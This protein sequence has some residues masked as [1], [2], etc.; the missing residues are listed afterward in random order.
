MSVR[1]VS[2][3]LQAQVGE[4]VAGLQRAK[5]ATGDF[6][7]ELAVSA[8]KGKGDLDAVARGAIIMGTALVGAVAGV[9][10]AG[11]RF[12]HAMAQVQAVS[13]ATSEEFDQ[14]R[15]AAIEMGATTVFSAS[16]AASATEELAKAGLSAAEITGGALAAS[17]NLAAA[18]GIGLAEAASL[19]AGNMRA[20]NMSA[21]EADRIA[22]TLAAGANRT[23]TTV[24]E[25][26]AALSNVGVVASQAGFSIEETVGALGAM[27]DNNV[28]AGEAGTNLKTSLLRLLAP[29]DQARQRM[30]QLGISVFDSQGNAKDLVSVVAELE[31]GLA[32]MTEQQRASTLQML[33]GQRA[34]IGANILLK[35]GSEGIAEYVEQVSEMGV[36]SDTA[37]QRLDSLQGDVKLLQSALESLAIESSGAATGGL[38]FLTQTF[39]TMVGQINNMPA[40]LLQTGIVLGGL[41][42]V[43]LL[44]G[45]TMLKLSASLARV[46]AQLVAMGP[47]GAVAARG[48]STVATWASRA[49]VAFLALQVAA[50]VMDQ[51]RDGAA[52]VELLANSLEHLAASGEVSGELMRVWG[53]N[54]EDA[55][56]AIHA[57]NDQSAA[58]GFLRFLESAAPP[59]AELSAA[60]AGGKPWAEW[61]AVIPLVGRRLDDTTRTLVSAVAPLSIFASELQGTGKTLAEMSDEVRAFEDALLQMMAQGLTT[62]AWDAFQE[63]IV[64]SGLTFGDWED[65]MPRFIAAHQA[66]TEE[67]REGREAALALEDSWQAIIDTGQQLADVFDELTGAARS[68]DRMQIRLQETMERVSEV[69]AENGKVVEEGA[70]TF[71]FSNEVVRESASALLDLADVI[72]DTVQATYEDLI[73]VT[74]DETAALEGAFSVYEEAK[75]HFIEQ[76]MEMGF[77][78][79]A[80]ERL[81][82][83]YLSMP[84]LVST[85]IK[86]PG[87]DRSIEDGA[88]LLRHLRDIDGFRATARVHT[89][90]TQAGGPV[91]PF[92]HGG[93]YINRDGGLYQ[94]QRGLLRRAQIFAPASPARFAF[95]EPETG[96]EAFI[97]RRGNRARSLAIADIAAQWHGGRV[98]P[99]QP[100][101]A[102]TFSSGI[103]LPARSDRPS[104]LSEAQRFTG[105]KLNL[106]VV[107]RNETSGA[108]DQLMGEIVRG[109]RTTVRLEGG[110]SVQA[111]L[112]Q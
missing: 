66:F 68:A 49:L 86:T 31:N 10:M 75:S 61:M 21:L 71:D 63:A 105:G 5:T 104:Q 47:A 12:E 69:I 92:R 52:D 78:R 97:P 83:R 6:R 108:T 73:Q 103:R 110:G 95:A 99:N 8:R 80:A 79:D 20:F 60:M 64:Q 22:D 51:F 101:G 98:V 41:V 65:A 93:V 56:A 100:T 45:G 44:V 7:N 24:S 72:G 59:L 35:E 88:R 111:A 15:A 39:T 13:G 3:R 87:M 90:Y 23:N 17:L 9:V 2:V 81:A 53:A 84:P 34:I 14:M 27:A 55:T 89:E 70:E 85:D 36:A 30:D 54:L 106:N 57:I 32:G 11:A 38:R 112:G 76:A 109:I 28:R 16:E 48:L 82:D 67:Q 50:A 58:A 94:A 96:G 40:P 25:L 37:A 77:T 26:G 107:V 1:S 4:Y 74:G 33:F 42:G 46:N 43:S 62:E 18:G 29:T 19:A 102:G 91:L